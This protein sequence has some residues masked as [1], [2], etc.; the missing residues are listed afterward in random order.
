VT[1]F[2]CDGEEI[3]GIYLDFEITDTF[4]KSQQTY[5]MA[6]YQFVYNEKGYIIS[7]A[8]GDPDQQDNLRNWIE[9]L[10]CI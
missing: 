7:Y 8:T 4:Y 2:A 9:T 6:Q 3:Q 5:Y 1:T 10:T